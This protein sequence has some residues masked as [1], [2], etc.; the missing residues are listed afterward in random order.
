MLRI[1]KADPITTREPCGQGKA[2]DWDSFAP[3][4]SNSARVDQ[5]ISVR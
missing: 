4:P 3:R 5:Y 1:R 2:I